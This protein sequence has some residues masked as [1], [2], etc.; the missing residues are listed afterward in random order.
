MCVYVY[1]YIYICVYLYI[2]IYRE[3]ERDMEMWLDSGI[4]GPR[5]RFLQMETIRELDHII[6][7]VHSS[8]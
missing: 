6:A 8:A 4:R 2:Y 1:I 3:R 7:Y 5:S